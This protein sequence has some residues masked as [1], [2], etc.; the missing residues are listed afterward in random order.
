MQL[1][2]YVLSKLSFIQQPPLLP[3]ILSM[4]ILLHAMYTAY[5]YCELHTCGFINVPV[6][7]TSV[8]WILNKNTHKKHTRNLTL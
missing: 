7:V 1:K 5:N 6:C 3:Q 8:F 2:W 4:S